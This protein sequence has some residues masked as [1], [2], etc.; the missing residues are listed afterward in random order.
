MHCFKVY[1]ALGL[2]VLRDRVLA[3]PNCQVNVEVKIL[4]GSTHD[5]QSDGSA[6]YRECTAKPEPTVKDGPKLAGSAVLNLNPEGCDLVIMEGVNKGIG[7]V[8]GPRLQ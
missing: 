5:L 8:F 4:E 3:L 1:L 6:L 7:I 2:Q